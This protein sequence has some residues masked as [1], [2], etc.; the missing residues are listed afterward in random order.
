M[1]Y[2][3]FTFRTLQI[4]S[5]SHLATLWHSYTNQVCSNLIKPHLETLGKT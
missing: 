5:L 4:P 1:L 2:A 3:T